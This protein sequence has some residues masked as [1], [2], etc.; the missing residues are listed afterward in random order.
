MKSFNF[1][2]LGVCIGVTVNA[3]APFP[4]I[5]A[6][7]L[8][9][10]VVLIGSRIVDATNRRTTEALR[11]MENLSLDDGF[12]TITAGGKKITLPREYFSSDRL[13]TN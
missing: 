5:A 11:Q 8:L 9:L 13:H 4:A 6:A 7:T 1:L 10:E 12:A 3:P 2:I